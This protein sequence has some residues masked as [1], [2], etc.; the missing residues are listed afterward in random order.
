MPTSKLLLKMLCST[1]C[2]QQLL[3]R[4]S[5]SRLN[6]RKSEAE[7]LMTTFAVPQCRSKSS[8]PGD[9]IHG[10][11]SAQWLPDRSMVNEASL[12]SGWDQQDPRIRAKH[13]ITTVQVGKEPR[14]GLECKCS[15]KGMGDKR[16]P[17]KGGKPCQS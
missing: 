3:A 7:S 11:P 17:G 4:N 8:R 16:N 14:Q 6:H 10:H 2:L 13:S 12:R 9:S 15:S 1:D 5:R